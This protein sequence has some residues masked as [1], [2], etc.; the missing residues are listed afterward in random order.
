MTGRSGRRGP[1]RRAE[2][3]DRCPACGAGIMK[4]ISWVAF[5]YRQ[6]AWLHDSCWKKEIARQ[7]AENQA[8]IDG[9]DPD[10]P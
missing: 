9:H 6:R 5:E 10:V 1:F 2:F 3:A 7:N 4:G 8:I